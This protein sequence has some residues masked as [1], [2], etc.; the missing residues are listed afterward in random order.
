VIG[1]LADKEVFV[2]CGG[3]TDAD[4]LEYTKNA[5]NYIGKVFT[6]KG[7]AWYPSGSIRHPKFKTWRADKQPEECTYDQIPETLR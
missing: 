3:L 1:T 5:D 4:R 6:A 7:N 2:T